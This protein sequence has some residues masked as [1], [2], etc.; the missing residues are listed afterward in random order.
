MHLTIEIVIS[1]TISVEARDILG[2]LFSLDKG[3]YAMKTFVRHA[4]M[5]LIIAAVCQTLALA[6][7]FYW[8]SGDSKAAS[9]A[10]AEK[11]ATPAQSCCATEAC[12]EESC[13]SC[14]SDLGCDECPCRGIVG[15]AGLDSFKGISDGDYPSNFGV[16]TGLNAAIP[17]PGLSDYGI[18]WQLGMSYG[19]YDIDGSAS[20]LSAR[21]QQQ[22]FVT[23]GFFHKARCD[24]RISFGL[25]YDWMI[26][27][28]WG[29]TGVNPTLGQ[30]RGQIE[31]ALSGC[32]SVGFWG[33]H[34]D[35]GSRIILDA[36][37]R[38]FL[39]SNRA[40]DQACLFWHHHFCCGADSFL[41][42]GVPDKSRLDSTEGGS[43]GDWMV[44]ASVTVPLTDRL[45]LYANGSYFRPSGAA[46]PQSAVEAGY[47][48]SMGVVW[49]FGGNAVSR[50]INGKCGLP[51]MNV[52]NNSTFLVDQGIQLVD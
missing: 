17:V 5:A 20:T 2:R 13:D 9:P 19:V 42:T 26:N 33:T 48:V 22:I 51:Y 45:G 43:L 34:R 36:G 47:D 30:W 10:P 27:N 16:V 28:Q 44:G 4:M 46:G 3:G 12:G 24:R 41:W 7:D 32:N 40:V 18:N 8:V 39:I 23:T 52:A 14:C 49:Y 25:V 1:G 31:Y 21:S 35:L 11:A 37:D 50:S 15:F 38:E 29:E 6:E